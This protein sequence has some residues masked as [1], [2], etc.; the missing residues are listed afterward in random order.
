MNNTAAVTGGKPI[1]IWS[2]SISDVSA[3]NLLVAFY[4]IHRRKREVLFLIL[5]CVET[6]RDKNIYLGAIIFLRAAWHVKPLLPAAFAV[7]N[8]YSNPKEGWRQADGCKNCSL[9][10]NIMK[11]CTD[12]TSW[13]NSREIGK[14]IVFKENNTILPLSHIKCRSDGN[15]VSITFVAFLQLSL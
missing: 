1:A 6:I 15:R 5:S 3:F 12:S 11:S 14:A 8:T 9:Y 13:D 10:H 2:Q 7:I 4:D